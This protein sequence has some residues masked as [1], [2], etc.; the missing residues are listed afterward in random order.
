MKRILSKLRRLNADYVKIPHELSL[1]ADALIQKGTMSVVGHTGAGK[2][3]LS[4]AVMAIVCSKMPCVYVAKNEEEIL[5]KIFGAGVLKAK[6]CDMFEFIRKYSTLLFP[7]RHGFEVLLNNMNCEDIDR[8]SL[9]DSV[10]RW[11]SLYLSKMMQFAGIDNVVVPGYVVA[12][13]S[14]AALGAIAAAA[15]AKVPAIA[16]DDA[17]AG[18]LRPDEFQ[19]LINWMRHMFKVSVITLHEHAVSPSITCFAPV[20]NEAAAKKGGYLDLVKDKSKYNCYLMGTRILIEPDKVYYFL[21][22]LAT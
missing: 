20:E 7:E 1:L 11:L 21:E 16:I 10:T 3:T 19:D 13:S 6:R 14:Y 5:E 18:V 9:N 12:S 22:Q 4:S 15:V 8:L 2:T 17:T